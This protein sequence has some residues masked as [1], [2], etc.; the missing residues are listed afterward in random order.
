MTEKDNQFEIKVAVAGIDPKDLNVEVT[1]DGL[2]VKG[3]TNTEK[4]EEK[5]E[6]HTSEFQS[7]SLFRSVQFPKKVD[8]NK[9]KAEIKNG[10]LTVVAPVA[11]EAKS[12]KVNIQAA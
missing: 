7:G 2:V 6:V 10:L 1:P 8:A 11:E 5:G 12:R 9:V 4:K 3:E